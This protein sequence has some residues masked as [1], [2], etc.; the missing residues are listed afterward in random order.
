[1]KIQD[2]K[3]HQIPGEENTKISAMANLALAFDFTSNMSVPLEF[4]P[5][6]S[7][8][9]NKIIYQV[10]VDPTWMDDSITYLQDEKLPSN[11]L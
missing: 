11:W 6:P 5:N 4:L 10:V 2:F 3:I 9:I 1:M 8:D 7:T